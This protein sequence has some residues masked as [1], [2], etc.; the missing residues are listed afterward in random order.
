[1]GD[2][3]GPTLPPLAAYAWDVFC[4]LHSARPVGMGGVSPITYSEVDAYCRLTGAQLS[5]LDVYLVRTI[6]E[7]FLTDI[8]RTSDAENAPTLHDLPPE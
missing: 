5:P 8:H 6:D 7:V 4:E 3:V 1:M 2:L